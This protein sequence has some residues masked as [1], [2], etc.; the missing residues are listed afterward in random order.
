M[1]TIAELIERLE[2]ATG[3]DRDIDKQLAAM[4]GTVSENGV[5]CVGKYV[6]VP[7]FTS[8]VHVAMDLAEHV[9][10]TYRLDTVTDPSGMSA[11]IIVWPGSLIDGHTEPFEGVSDSLAV[12]ICIAILKAKE[13]LPA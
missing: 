13:A 6:G 10:P 7:L 4:F 9:F 8:M 3:P 11:K 12:A 1:S 5:P 2:K